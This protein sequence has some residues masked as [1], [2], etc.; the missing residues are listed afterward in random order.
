MKIHQ[1]SVIPL[2]IEQFFG[3]QL[4]GTATGFAIRH[5][6]KNFIITNWH[7]VTGKHPETK[8]CLHSQAALPNKLKIWLHIKDKLGS[9]NFQMIDLYREGKSIWLGHPTESVYDVVAIP[10][11]PANNL[12]LYP[13]DLGLA[14][15]DMVLEPADRVSIIGF[16]HGIST[17]GKLPI[18]KTGHVASD[19]DVDWSG[20]PIFLIDA[21]TKGGMSGSPVIAKRTEGYRSS[22][23][24]HLSGSATKFLGIYSSRN[25][26][27]DGIEIGLVWKPQVIK[28]IIKQT[29]PSAASQTPN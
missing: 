1:L 28:E 25:I 2:H 23:A 10:I 20:K 11:E 16:P 13:L 3:E 8:E 18:W 12:T 7:A 21:T 14:E 22:Q 29:E 6:N 19:I 27:L 5:N 17:A 26:G 24:T 4:L 15:V 9:W